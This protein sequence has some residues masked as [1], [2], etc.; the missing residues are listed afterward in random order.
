MGV[1]GS[2]IVVFHLQVPTYWLLIRTIQT[3]AKCTVCLGS[4]SVIWKRP[5]RGVRELCDLCCTTLFN[6]HWICPRCGYAVCMDCFCS[7]AGLLSN[8]RGRHAACAPV[9]QQCALCRNGGRRW[10]SCTATNGEQHVPQH[11]LL[12]QIIPSDGV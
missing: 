12:T 7:A 5:L 2:R 9:D 10:H 6:V 8:R 1:C 4:E 11:M 3:P